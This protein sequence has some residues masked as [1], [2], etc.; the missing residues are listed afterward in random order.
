MIRHSKDIEKTALVVRSFAIIHNSEWD[1]EL[2]WQNVMQETGVKS[3]RNMEELLGHLLIGVGPELN[4]ERRKVPLLKLME[5]L[6]RNVLYMAKRAGVLKEVNQAM[7]HLAKMKN[8]NRKVK[9]NSK[10]KYFHLE[11][12]EGQ[13]VIKRVR[14]QSA[15]SDGQVSRLGKHNVFTAEMNDSE[16]LIDVKLKHSGHQHKDSTVPKQSKAISFNNDSQINKLSS[17]KN[18]KRDS[19]NIDS[20]L[21]KPK[22]KSSLKLTVEDFSNVQRF[23]K[24]RKY[25]AVKSRFKND[26][27]R[28]TDSDLQNNKMESKVRGKS[29]SLNEVS[30]KQVKGLVKNKFKRE[31]EHIGKLS[32]LK[33]VSGDLVDI[34]AEDKGNEMQLNAVS[35]KVELPNPVKV[36]EARESKNTKKDNLVIRHSVGIQKKLSKLPNDFKFSD[37]EESNESKEERKPSR[38]SKAVQTQMKL[39]M[40][41]KS[42]SVDLKSNHDSH[43]L[44]V[45]KVEADLKLSKA[46]RDSL[47]LVRESINSEDSLI[48]VEEL[49]RKSL[50][51]RGSKGSSHNGSVENDDFEIGNIGNRQSLQQNKLEKAKKEGQKRHYSEANKLLESG[52]GKL[53]VDLAQ[54]NKSLPQ[55]QC[56]SF[57]NTIQESFSKELK[58]TD[59]NEGLTTNEKGQKNTLKSV[60][61]AEK[62]SDRS[63][64]NVLKSNSIQSQNKDDQFVTFKSNSMVKKSKK[65]SFVINFEKSFYKTNHTKSNS[66]TKQQNGQSSSS[67]TPKKSF[68]IDNQTFKNLANQKSGGL[69]GKKSTKN[70]SLATKNSQNKI[71]DSTNKDSL[72]FNSQNLNHF[73]PKI[74]NSAFETS[75]NAVLVENQIVIDKQR[76]S[77]D[78]RLQ[79]GKWKESKPVVYNV[80]KQHKKL[81]GTL[82]INSQVLKQPIQEL[83]NEN[84]IKNI[85][86]KN[87]KSLM[88]NAVKWQS[89]YTKNSQNDAKQYIEKSSDSLNDNFRIEI[90]NTGTE[91]EKMNIKKSLK[92]DSKGLIFENDKS[93]VENKAS[94]T[95]IMPN[96]IITKVS[97]GSFEVLNL[98]DLRKTSDTSLKRT[99]N[100]PIHHSDSVNH[101]DNKKSFASL[102]KE[103]SK[104]GSNVGDVVDVLNKIR[105][106]SSSKFSDTTSSLSKLPNQKIDALNY[107]ENA[108]LIE[109]ND[110]QK[111]TS[112]NDSSN[113]LLDSKNERE[114]INQSSAISPAHGLKVSE[115][116]S[117]ILRNEFG[118]PKLSFPEDK[119]SV[120][121][122]Y[123]LNRDSN[124]SVKDCSKSESIEKTSINLSEQIKNISLGKQSEESYNSNFDNHNSKI[125]KADHITLVSHEDEFKPDFD[126]MHTSTNE[127]SIRNLEHH[128]FEGIDKRSFEKKSLNNTQKVDA[129]SQIRNQS[130][131]KKELS[132]DKTKLFDKQP[133]A[134][135]EDR[136]VWNHSTQKNS[137]TANQNDHFYD[138]IGSKKNKPSFEN[139][140]LKSNSIQTPEFQQ[141]EFNSSKNKLLE[142]K[143]NKQNDAF[144]MLS[145]SENAKNS[146]KNSS[147]IKNKTENDLEVV[148]NDTNLTT[149]F[150]NLKNSKVSKDED[151]SNSQQKKIENSILSSLVDKEKRNPTLQNGKGSD[152]NDKNTDFQT[153]KVNLINSKMIDDDEFDEFAKNT[154][155]NSLSEGLNTERTSQ[156]AKINDDFSKISQQNPTKANFQTLQSTDLPQTPLTFHNTSTRLANS[157]MTKDIDYAEINLETELNSVEQKSKS[158]SI[159]DFSNTEFNSNKMQTTGS[160][161]VKSGFLNQETTERFKDLNAF[162]QNESSTQT[163]PLVQGYSAEQFPDSVRLM[164]SNGFLDEQQLDLTMETKQNSLSY[165]ETNTQSNQFSDRNK[166]QL[167]KTTTAQLVTKEVDNNFS[168]NKKKEFEKKDQMVQ[169]YTDLMQLQIGQVVFRN[170]NVFDDN[171]ITSLKLPTQKNSI[172]TNEVSFFQSK[173]SNLNLSSFQPGSNHSQYDLSQGEQ[174]SMK[175]SAAKTTQKNSILILKNNFPD[176]KLNVFLENEGLL[177]DE[178]DGKMHSNTTKAIK[179]IPT[180]KMLIEDDAEDKMGRTINNSEPLDGRQT[181]VLSF[182]NDSFSKNSFGKQ[183]HQV[184][185]STMKFEMNPLMSAV[186]IK[187]MQMDYRNAALQ[188]KAEIKDEAIQL[189]ERKEREK[190]QSSVSRKKFREKMLLDNDDEIRSTDLVEK[191]RKLFKWNSE[192]LG[193]TK[194]QLF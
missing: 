59:D 167:S 47:N 122:A 41:D 80:E 129:S 172:E 183:S 11:E 79:N 158:K 107:A 50:S 192:F 87:L 78:N 43:N 84:L 184:G 146:L 130:I 94:S 174:D 33:D 48:K 106:N 75:Q 160:N 30:N 182:E 159:T 102:Q 1:F 4:N 133:F 151:Y 125:A 3:P 115:K 44:F 76:L 24:N 157:K 92:N 150:V 98:D 194:Y 81:S 22:S 164:N 10:V 83:S 40:S 127:N 139:I 85:A 95:Q 7:K 137:L 169:K 116:N 82:E 126:M 143:K 27:R 177:E 39:E 112:L 120:S 161:F 2:F 119:S 187:K 168:K 176:E 181:N 97:D 21:D 193:R 178:E 34:R 155:S 138:N 186:D 77:I 72:I 26:N 163:N 56:P 93:D 101:E 162:K 104:H 117:S 140:D 190:S 15:Q 191:F 170:S 89:I 25:S 144:S 36:R 68:Q 124:V 49:S 147:I 132:A 69:V 103:Y 67:P 28:A 90:V 165:V 8:W 57:R 105:M 19:K 13:S 179:L 131:E 166:Q 6:E 109:T 55:N 86:R 9:K 171:N 156:L 20:R 128:R 31:I 63:V 37:K 145:Q 96:K 70:E 142:N 74:S 111:K 175:A 14:A 113:Q 61:N 118:S 29:K 114:N 5:F 52:K 149:K 18:S 99:D 54:L 110:A 188:R 64:K 42:N 71:K 173:L 23:P 91:N 35:S 62:K 88:K 65:Y 16:A 100:K 154:L 53:S 153:K 152:S 46:E 17:V 123:S 73:D 134:K 38:W 66:Q 135:L 108:H 185:Q 148:T 45:D 141:T 32:D 136:S 121:Q 60:G 180:Q 58:V 12:E 189:G 51:R